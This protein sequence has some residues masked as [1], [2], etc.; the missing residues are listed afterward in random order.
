MLVH[1]DFDELAELKRKAMEY[2]RS[3]ARERLR[4]LGSLSDVDTE[5]WTSILRDWDRSTK[6]KI[7]AIVALRDLSGCNLAQAKATVDHF[8]L[9]GNVNYFN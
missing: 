3:Q 5:I 1:I 9:T 6:V 2:D 7:Q 8:I 4:Q